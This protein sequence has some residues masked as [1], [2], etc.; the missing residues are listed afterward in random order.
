MN[1]SKLKK[2]LIVSEGLRLKPYK[3]TTG[4]LTIGVGRNLEDV[5][6]AKEEAFFLLK[7]DIQH[8]QNELKK[9]PDFSKLA[10]SEVRQRVV[11]EMAFNIGVNR[12]LKFKKM[13]AAISFGN[14]DIAAKEMLNSKWAKQ[15]GNRAYRLAKRMK[16]GSD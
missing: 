8:L 9:I 14:W 16:T 6:I 12:L 7:R 11:A 1:F 4:K 3:D 2:D 5:G 10:D 15:V 13:W